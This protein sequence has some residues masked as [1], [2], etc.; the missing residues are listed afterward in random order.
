MSDSVR[1]Y[2]LRCTTYNN[3]NITYDN[4]TMYP[5]IR[6]RY[7][8]VTVRGIYYY[9]I[10]YLLFSVTGGGC[11]NDTYNIGNRHII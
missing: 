8:A 2:T 11:S 5:R 3:N 1:L 7:S 6:L 9:Y 4:N 10:T